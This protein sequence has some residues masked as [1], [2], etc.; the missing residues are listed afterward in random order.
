[1]ILAGFQPTEESV[2]MRRLAM[3]LAWGY[4]SKDLFF[5]LNA[6]Y[7]AHH[8]ACMVS[9]VVVLWSTPDALMYLA[10]HAVFVS[11]EIGS[12]VSALTLVFEPRS[13]WWLSFHVITMTASNLTAFWVFQFLYPLIAHG[14][15]IF[16]FLAVAALIRQ[17]AAM[18]S[19][20]ELWTADTKTVETKDH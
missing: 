18:E 6:A 3:Y 14:W 8:I 20:Y 4:V 19:V 7:M 16:I 11:M 10:A 13:K 2:Y 12:L 9:I 17:Q 15:L 1:M 5:P